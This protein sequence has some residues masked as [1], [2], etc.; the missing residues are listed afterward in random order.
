MVYEGAT[1]E[2]ENGGE[3]EREKVDSVANDGFVSFHLPLCLFEFLS[4]LISRDVPRVNIFRNG[5]YIGSKLS[6]LVISRR[7]IS[8][9]RNLANSHPHEVLPSYNQGLEII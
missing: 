9:E 6:L 3:R 8:L 4:R 1:K 7:E 5:G 2:K